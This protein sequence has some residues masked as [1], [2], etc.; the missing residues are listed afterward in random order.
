MEWNQDIFNKNI[1]RLLNGRP[2]KDLN[3]TA[4]RD[5]VTRWKNG[6]RPSLEILLKTSSFFNCGI[7]DL[8]KNREEVKGVG[9][10]PYCEENRAIHDDVESIMACGNATLIGTF[11]LGLKGVLQSM[12][13][14]RGDSELLRSIAQSFEKQND[15]LEKLLSGLDT[16]APEL[17][18]GIKKLLNAK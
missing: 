6:D 2:Q 8:I 5:A 14:F 4:G 12:G 18:A 9:S 1:E 17:G 15:I 3:K 10:Y 16:A 11:T 13:H 7:D